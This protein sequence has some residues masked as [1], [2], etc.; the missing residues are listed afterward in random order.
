MPYKPSVSL[1][2]LLTFHQFL[3]AMQM[4]IN[5]R[6]RN[7]APVMTRA[8][9][10]ISDFEAPS[11]S[12]SEPAMSRSNAKN[13]GRTPNRY[14]W[15]V[16]SREPEILMSIGSVADKNLHIRGQLL[17]HGCRVWFLHFCPA[18]ASRI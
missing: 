2:I 13:R 17:Q 7:T 3:I 16:G 8:V 1:Y 18:A 5:P 11:F 9:W 10:L 12:N 14:A 6:E 15:Y 4:L